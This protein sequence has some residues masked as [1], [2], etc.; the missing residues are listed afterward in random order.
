M[1]IW[2]CRW[3]PT[4]L[5]TTTSDAVAR[6][7]PTAEPEEQLEGAKTGIWAPASVLAGSSRSPDAHSKPES[8]APSQHPRMSPQQSMLYHQQTND[9][10]DESLASNADFDP[11]QV[12]REPGYWKW[13]PWTSSNTQHAAQVNN[14]SYGAVIS[15]HCQR[16]L[17]CIKHLELPPALHS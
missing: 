3:F 6:W 16:I 5:W 7:L 15:L 9:E 14:Q 10:Q 8:E 13:L 12:A 17:Q 4:A 1:T 11:S 2:L